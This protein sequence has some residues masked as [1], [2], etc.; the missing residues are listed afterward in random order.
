MAHFFSDF[1]LILELRIRGETCLKFGQIEQQ[2][3]DTLGKMIFYDE[4][5]GEKYG[6]P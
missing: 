6:N 5:T 2:P 3:S 1:N 4:D